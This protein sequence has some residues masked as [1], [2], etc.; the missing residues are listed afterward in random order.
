MWAV[1]HGP[2]RQSQRGDIYKDVASKLLEA[3]YAYESFSTSEEIEAR[4]LVCWSS[5]AAFG[6]DGYDRNLTEERKKPSVP[7]VAKPAIRIKMPDENIRFNDLI[8][9]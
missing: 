2:Y 9:W 3:G 8:R 6:Y 5:E 1:P 4:N 7:K